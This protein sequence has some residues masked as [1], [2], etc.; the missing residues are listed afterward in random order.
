ML[1]IDQNFHHH[2]LNPAALEILDGPGHREAVAR[3][4]HRGRSRRGRQGDAQEYPE[5]NEGG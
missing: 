3:L 5:Q 2:F 4:F 1:A